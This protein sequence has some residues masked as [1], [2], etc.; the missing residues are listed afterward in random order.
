MTKLEHALALAADG[1][2]VFPLTPGQKAPPL[3]AN[4]PTNATRSRHVIA[5]WWGQWP[6]A[7]I[8]ISTTCFGDDQ[9]LLAVDID[10]K[11]GI[12]GYDTVLWLELEG[13]ALPPPARSIPPMEDN[14]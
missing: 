4:F 12:S 11:K 13:W 7:N 14:T 9:A 6:D 10:N 8:G 5:G 2:H 3:I 1:F